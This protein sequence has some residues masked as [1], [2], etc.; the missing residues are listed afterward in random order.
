MRLE[1]SED[2]VHIARRHGIIYFWLWLLIF[3]LIGTPFFFMFWLFNHSWWGQSL[4]FVPLSIGLFL[5]I[6]TVFLWKK[7]AAI[8][9]THRVIDVDQRGFFDKFVSEIHYDDL[10]CI[11]GHIKGFWG[12]IW[13]Y[14][15]VSIQNENGNMKIVLDRIKQPVHIQRRINELR[16]EHNTRYSDNAIC[17]KCRIKKGNAIDMIEDRFHKLEVTELIKLKRILDQKIRKLLEN[18]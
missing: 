6:R 8:I 11:S 2:I 5:L 16:K 17:L 15:V 13:R 1:K 4:F 12:T 3:I 14:G 9:T 10:D 7:N 18:D